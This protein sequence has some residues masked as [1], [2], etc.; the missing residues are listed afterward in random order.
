[1]NVSLLEADLQLSKIELCWG[2]LSSVGVFVVV[3]IV[4]RAV[5]LCPGLFHVSAW[6]TS[7]YP[8]YRSVRNVLLAHSIL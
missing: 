2:F 4:P 1:M 7:C 3:V 5:T 6:V 8:G